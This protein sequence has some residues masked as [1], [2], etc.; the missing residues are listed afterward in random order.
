MC[1]CAV[2]T[3]LSCMS[4][5]VFPLSRYGTALTG[6][7]VG[8]VTCMP[9]TG[10]RIGKV[11]FTP[12]SNL[13]SWYVD[14]TVH[15]SF[16]NREEVWLMYDKMAQNWLTLDIPKLSYYYCLTSLKSLVTESLYYLDCYLVKLCVNG[17]C[18]MPVYVVFLSIS[19]SMNT[20]FILAKR[21]A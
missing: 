6:T 2:Y 1:F 9:T 20:T 10:K 7:S 19:G 13:C 3:L 17:V 18:C 5:T 8:Y 16:H 11:D 14:S 21:G 15:D 12:P 4:Y